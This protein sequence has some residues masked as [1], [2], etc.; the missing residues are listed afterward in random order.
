VG[1][2]FFGMRGKRTQRDKGTDATT[3]FAATEATLPPAAR[4]SQPPE[5][6]IDIQD[7]PTPSGVMDSQVMDSQV[8]DS[9]V[10]DSQI[11]DSCL[12]AGSERSEAEAEADTLTKSQPTLSH[13]GRY[14]LKSRLGQG[15]LGQ[16]H[17]AWDPLLSRTVAVKTLQFDLPGP[18]RAS[19]DGM[20]LN[21]ARA[22]AS[23]NHAYI[24]TV[25]DAGLS[26]HGV[27]IAMERLQGRDLR[28]ALAQGWMPSPRVAAVLVRR[29]ADALAYAHGRGVVHCDIKPANIF[30]VGRDR[31]KVLDFGIARI[32]H[33]TAVPAL[34]GSVAG[35]PHYQAPEQVRGQAV[36]ARTD[37]YALGTVLY[38]LLTGRRAFGGDSVDQIQTAVLT[39]H[40]APAH[41][42]RPGVPRALSEIAARAM[43]RDPAER[44]ASATEMSMAL[45]RWAEAHASRA[46]AKAE[47]P[48]REPAP[49]AAARGAA[50][51]GRRPML[52]LGGAL[53][54][55]GLGA[56]LVKRRTAPA[57]DADLAALSPGETLLPAASAASAATMAAGADT[58]ASAAASALPPA[59]ALAA[60]TAATPAAAAPAARPPAPAPAKPRPT[61]AK[62]QAPASAARPAP[63]TGTVQLAISPWGRVEVNGSPAG[64]A[65]PLT[66][67]TLPEGTHTI[68]VHNEDFPPFVTTVQVNADKPA[69]LRHRFGP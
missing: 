18:L 12:P 31:P 54:A 39:L 44:F 51:L 58:T 33:G 36:D 57:A 32:A 5:L 59:T 56:L 61:P 47:A 60:S 48:A 45:R 42:V 24:V 20:I 35:S 43:A 38:E 62:T 13:V 21:E 68:T 27:Y 49:A 40:P 52:L 69:T 17:E 1:Y 34:D 19:L 23:L 14:A 4:E 63:A 2:H 46:K 30:L 37:L 67:L 41:E 28:H 7:E 3:E 6:D 15:G 10:M 55:V 16:V 11:R 64:T 8:T 22:A 29:V 53:A 26:A 66:R 65:P 9:Q 50:G 25:F